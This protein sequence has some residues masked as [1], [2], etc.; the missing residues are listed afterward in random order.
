MLSKLIENGLNL[1]ERKSDTFF[2]AEFAI[3]MDRLHKLD[4]I[5]KCNPWIT[6][7]RD[8]GTLLDVA[9]LE[10]N[11]NSVKMLLEAGADP[12]QRTGKP[13]PLITAI[14]YRDKE[15]AKLLIQH[16]ADVNKSEYSKDFKGETPAMVAA[17]HGDMALFIMLVE[18]GADLDKVKSNGD[19]IIKIAEDN[20]QDE[21][22]RYILAL[23]DQQA[24]DGFIESNDDNQLIISF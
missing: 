10:G 22:V 5:L 1:I 6:Q 15:T 19:T 24:L 14:S 2:R 21:I 7:Y 13:A 4:V 20:K 17:I 11:V 12:N 8:R 3:R 16:G 9:V 18:S 23:N